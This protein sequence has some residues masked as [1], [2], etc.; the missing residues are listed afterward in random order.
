MGEVTDPAL[1]AQLN[2]GGEVTDSTVLGQLNA[3]QSSYQPPTFAQ[4]AA[5]YGLT[6]AQQTEPTNYPLGRE[7]ADLGANLA[8][9]LGSFWPTIGLRLRQGYN[10]I[11]GG[12]SLAPEVQEKRKY[13]AP[14]MSTVGGKIGTALPY[15]ALTA[16][17]PGAG[18]LYG[19]IG[20]GALTGL[21]QPT[22]NASET[23]WNTGGGAAAGAVGYGIG[24]L[25][26]RWA[27]ERSEYP[28]MGWTP[29]S[30]D[31]EL[32]RAVG[33]DAP[34][35]DQAA[36]GQR[37]TQLGQVF[38][39]G[40]NAA[41]DI[42]LAAT[43]EVLGR[44]SSE[45]NPSARALFENNPNVLDLTGH[46]TG[47][48]VV[49]GQMLGRISTGLRQD[50]SSALNAEG[51]NREVGMALQGLRDHVEDLIQGGIS[52]PALRAS[53]AAARPQYG[54]LQDVRYSPN[55]LNASTGRANME[56]LGK[57]L[58]RNNS[59]Y[60]SESAMEN[61]LFNAAVWGQRGGGAK[62]PPP[63]LRHLGM[64]WLGYRA[65]HNVLSRAVG[66][67]ASNAIAPIAPVLPQGLGSLAIGGTAVAIPYVEQ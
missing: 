2:G 50:A 55:I 16:V 6:G 40:R 12:P 53:Y 54:L 67:A 4:T 41:T 37:A 21:A 19:A 29:Q 32:A 48:G 35:L 39:A 7:L 51:G 44:I 1:L 26:G 8:T 63:M 56:A 60:T 17:A 65:T 42:D 15:A 45:L 20:Y 11:T 25:I 9:G 52:D 14:L 23:L 66:G 30:A 64:D 38:N 59:A 61:P 62:G 18:T 22:V 34:A 57:Y 49:N 33:S 27:T 13:D 31:A 3:T 58:Q 36:L 10:A 24:S 47:S 28:F 43:P 46:A 5:Q